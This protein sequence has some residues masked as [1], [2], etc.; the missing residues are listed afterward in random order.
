MYAAAKIRKKIFHDIGE[1]PF[2]VRD[3]FEYGTRSAV[4]QVFYRLAKEGGIIRIAHGLFIKADAPMPTP[5][6]AAIAKAAAFNKTIA[7]HGSKAAQGL[8]LT[9]QS[10]D[11]HVF[12]VSGSSSSF[13][14]GDKII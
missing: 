13:R 11:E 2:S 10:S 1:K 3:F 5:T 7:I 14:F 8:K 12:A 9:N 6:E 4:Y